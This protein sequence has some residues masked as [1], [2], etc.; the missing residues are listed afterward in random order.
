MKRTKVKKLLSLLCLTAGL[1]ASSSLAVNQIKTSAA[2]PATEAVDGVMY[3]VVDGRAEVYGLE[4]GYEED[5]KIPSEVSI[6]DSTYKVG[7][8][9]KIKKSSSTKNTCLKSIDMSEAVYLTEIGSN[10]FT[11]C[12]VL[13]N[14]I[15]P[16]SLSKFGTTAFK[17]CD[18]IE[19]VTMPKS[20]EKC[21][22]SGIFPDCDNLKKIIIPEGVKEI[23]SGA[24]RDTTG[25][26]SVE[27]PNSVTTI[28][29][30][31]F[32]DCLNLDN[33][34]IP[35]SVQKVMSYAFEGCIYLRNLTISEGVKT[36]Y[37]EAFE[38]CNSLEE[39]TIPCT[40]SFSGSTKIGIFY[41]CTGL[42]KVVFANG[43]KTIAANMLACT[44]GLEEVVIPNTVKSI[45]KYSFYQCMGLK[46]IAIPGTVT[47][48]DD[49]AFDG[50]ILEQIIGAKD[51]TASAYAQANG[52]KFI[53][54]DAYATPTPKPTATNTPKPTATSTPK[55]T[56]T[57]TPKPTATST[58]KPKATNTPKP[59]EISR[60]KIPT[61]VKIQK[62]SSSSMKLSWKKVK[63][64]DGYEIYVANKKNFSD[65]KITTA[66]KSSVSKK[67]TKKIPGKTYYVK[68][69]A[70]KKSGSKKIY[71]KFSK[72]VKCK[73]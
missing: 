26:T 62:I 12:T 9:T 34:V 57:S 71:G 22:T 37:H 46:S 29:S 15:F 65:K 5:I 11:N 40:V 7:K 41:K 8:I 49:K 13:T 45:G 20:F 43:T 32:R 42:K 52:Y 73:L 3:A 19:E 38:E 47:E 66:S 2:D 6:F 25:L 67:L 50:G 64:I 28:N 23:P 16:D 63:N 59:T 61:G 55:P 70:Y 44:T 51:S 54:D 14:V 24:F 1:I 36:I 21:G 48:I 18:S 33:V 17:N 56:A 35:S 10:T 31:A 53:V 72:V 4:T 69:R 58:P 27:I 60:P 39:V 68:I 30:S